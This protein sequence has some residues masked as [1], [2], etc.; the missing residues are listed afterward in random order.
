MAKPHPEISAEMAD[1]IRQQPLFFVASAP[2]SGDGHVNLSPKGH[3]TLRVLGPHRVAY[4]DLT[5]SGNETAA[6]LTENGRIT[7]MFSAFSGPPQILRLF[8]QGRV[9]LPQDA[10]WAELAGHFEVLPGTR[11]I[12][13]VEVTRVQTSCGFAVPKM[14]VVVERDA[15][16]KWAEKKGPE[17]LAEYRRQK[18]RVS[19]DG[20]EPPL[21][22]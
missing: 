13:V 16:L 5:G 11:Q 20:L 14:E 4:L 9:V 17:A 1:F 10:D 6:H 15:L 18:N 12:I 21:A 3:D 19:L 22:G 7:I 2:L 8:G